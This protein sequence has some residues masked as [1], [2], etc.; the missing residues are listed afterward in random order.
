[1]LYSATSSKN[2]LLVYPETPQDSYWSFSHTLRLV[3]KKVSMPPLGVLTI[4]AMLPSDEF[5]PRVVDMNAKALTNDDIAWADVVFVSAM[6]VQKDSLEETIARLKRAGKIV[7]AGGPYTSTAYRE[8]AGVDCF[9]IGE[10]EAVWEPFLADLKAGALKKAY[11]A[12]VRDSE[13]QAITD[14]FGDGA[15]IIPADVYPDINIAPI[16]RFDL[17]EINDYAVMPVQASRGCPVGCEFCDIWRRFGRK[18]RNKTPERLRAELD[19]LHRLGW[20]D[21]IFLV[22]DNFI[23]NKRRALEILDA[24]VDWQKQHDY[25]MTFLTEATLSLADDDMLLSGMANAGFTSV[26]VG[27]E[28]PYEESLKETRKYINTLGSMADKV[29]KIQ[30]AG[31]QLMSGFIIGFDSDPDDIAK[32]MT[33]CIQEMGIP[34]AMIGILNAL[35]ETDL[36]E[37]LEAE[38]RIRFQTSG[39]NTHGFAINF[40]PKRPDSQVLADYKQILEAAYPRDMKNYFDR[41]A[42]LRRRWPRSKSISPG[43]ISTMWKIKAVANCLIAAGKSSYRWNAYRFLAVSLFTK[44]SFFEEAV[45]LCVKAHH[46]WAITGQAF[47]VEE[48]REIMHGK[49]R[50]YT[51]FIRNRRAALGE[52]LHTLRQAIPD[53]KTAGD[54]IPDVLNRLKASLANLGDRTDLQNCHARVTATLREIEAYSK[55]IQSETERE[56]HRLSREARLMLQTELERFRSEANILYRNFWNEELAVVSIVN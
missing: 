47:E 56:F 15:H 34:Q 21:A 26:F 55:R 20:S 22:D 43:K 46:L 45:S 18:S 10:A 54:S 24:L 5:V 2:I 1:M 41:C 3:G 8:T 52:A 29:A 50:E 11:A 44:P 53:A 17:I 49:L 12:P 9:V 37:R 51:D 14:Y 13:R 42:V 38:G 48:M 40:D 19:E 25:P 33:K 4:A 7:V 23:G 36:Y 31:I 6:I 32:R 30:A 27:I 16:P 35:P 28:T 39:N